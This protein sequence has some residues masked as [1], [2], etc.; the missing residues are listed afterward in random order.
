[1]KVGTEPLHGPGRVVTDRNWEMFDPLPVGI[2]LIDRDY[3]VLFWNQCIARWTGISR[4]AMVG[5]D[6]RT[7]FA[8]LASRVYTSRI[9]QVFEGGPAAVFSSQFHP[10]FIPALLQ[11]GDLLAEHASVIPFDHNG[12]RLGMIVIE[13]INDLVSQVRMYRATRQ[14]ANLEIEERKKAQEALHA[15]NAKL[16][17]LS[18]LTRHDILNQVTGI[19]SYLYLLENGLEPGSQQN[20]YVQ[21]ISHQ[22]EVI[23]HL[24]EITREYEQLGISAP[25]WCDVRSIVEHSA[26]DVFA[27]SIGI[28]NALPALEVYADPMFGKVIFNIFENAKYHGK[29][30]TTIRVGF[31]SDKDQGILTLED[32]GVGIPAS[33][34]TRIFLKGVGSRTGLGLYLSQE[35]L[36]ITGL[37]IRETGTPGTGARFEILIPQAMFRVR[38]R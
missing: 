33:E 13:D 25:D 30:V 38:A 2:I 23:T 21:K 17:L 35:I 14:L 36:S 29:T 37:E 4:D 28:E 7:Q 9:D 26:Q 34:K 18:S 6:L 10:H 5:C 20:E 1:M 32:N 24:L 15:A 31:S 27:G 22:V 3:T 16:N 11:N 8:H 12:M 19:T